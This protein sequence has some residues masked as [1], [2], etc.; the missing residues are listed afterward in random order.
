MVNSNDNI[1]YF[2]KCK[3]TCVNGHSFAIFYERS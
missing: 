2:P 1:I 3:V